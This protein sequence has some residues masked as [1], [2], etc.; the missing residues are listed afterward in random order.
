MA[1]QH[2]TA[3][4]AACRQDNSSFQSA[5]LLLFSDESLTPELFFKLYRVSCCQ[6]I[7]EEITPPS[8][9]VTY[10]VFNLKM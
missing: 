2:E 8:A 10:L 9:S 5:I 1:L 7:Y 3:L 6:L 4:K